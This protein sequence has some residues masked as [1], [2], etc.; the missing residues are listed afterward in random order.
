M[1]RPQ[2]DRA[3]DAGASASGRHALVEPRP[4]LHQRVDQQQPVAGCECRPPDL[5]VPAVVVLGGPLGVDGLRAPQPRQDF[6]WRRDTRRLQPRRRVSVGTVGYRGRMPTLAQAS[7]SADEFALLTRFAA[8]LHAQLDKA[9]Y[10]V[11]L[12]GSRA[13]GERPD[14]SSDVDVLVLVDDASLEGKQRVYAAFD[15]AANSLRLE[16]LTP[17]FSV[18]IHT[19]EW[20]ESRR[21]IES[22]FIAEVDRDK[23]VVAGSV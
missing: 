17:W 7:L 10:A 23:I 12:F 9:L 8:M 19:R 21:E 4:I 13:R 16:A 11:W 20:L 22:F 15:E 1:R 5:R 2:T 14:D 6:S 18:H 3:D